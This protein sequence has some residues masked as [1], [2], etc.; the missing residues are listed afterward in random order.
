MLV[1]RRGKAL[2]LADVES[3]EDSVGH[4]LMDPEAGLLADHL[5]AS[6]L[7][8]L[9]NDSGTMY[10]LNQ[11]WS[12]G[13]LGRNRRSLAVDELYLLPRLLMQAELGASERS[14]MVAAEQLVEACIG[15]RLRIRVGEFAR[16]SRESLV[17][18][19]PEEVDSSSDQDP[20]A[21]PDGPDE[22]TVC[23][24]LNRQH[25]TFQAHATAARDN[26]LLA[27][28]GLLHVLTQGA[29]VPRHPRRPVARP[30]ARRL[31]GDRA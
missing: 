22:K 15:G 4:V 1:D 24:L 27:A 5:E 9:P 16:G 19:G 20:S 31:I 10:L 18:D 29:R 17:V 6:G 11:T 7:R 23:L 2:S 8:L 28:V 25:R 26:P 13:L 12:A 14:M 30:A 3:Q 21:F